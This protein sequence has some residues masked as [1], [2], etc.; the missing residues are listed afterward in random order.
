MINVE[1]LFILIINQKLPLGILA[2]RVNPLATMMTAIYLTTAYILLLI[3]H[4]Q[5]SIHVLIV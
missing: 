3:Y 5:L 4:I 1:F 2:L